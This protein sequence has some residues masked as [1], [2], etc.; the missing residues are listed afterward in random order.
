MSEKTLTLP[1][2]GMTCANCVRSV[3]RN[4]GKVEGVQS[5]TVN[6]ATEQATVTYDPAVAN[7][8]AVIER[9][10]KAGYGVP[11]ATLE[12][13]I[14]GM[15]CTN[16]SNTVQRR[17]GKLDGVLEASVNFANEMVES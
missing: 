1:I 13:P 11:V 8:Q 3:E 14:T 5:A 10:E 12:L 16:C 6:F 9:I 15:T 2:T 4:A 17:L 7:P